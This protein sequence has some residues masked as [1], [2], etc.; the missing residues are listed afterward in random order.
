VNLQTDIDVRKEK[1]K[2]SRVLQEIK[3]LAG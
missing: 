3:T 2:H 1:I